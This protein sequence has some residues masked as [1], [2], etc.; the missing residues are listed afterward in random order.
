MQYKYN[1]ALIQSIRAGVDHKQFRHLTL[2]LNFAVAS[3]LSPWLGLRANIFGIDLSV[4]LEAQSSGF[5]VC[6]RQPLMCNFL[7]WLFS[8]DN[9]KKVVMPN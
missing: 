9:H 1:P 2:A 4:S 8:E 7:Q 3:D 5:V 6:R